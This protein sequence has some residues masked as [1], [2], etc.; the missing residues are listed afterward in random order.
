[1]NAKRV[2]LIGA[3]G[4]VGGHVLQSALDDERVASLTVIGRRPTGVS[5]PKLIEIVHPNLL[6]YAPVAAALADQNLA[7][8]CLGAIP[9]PFPT[10]S[11]GGSRSTTSRPFPRRST[12]PA[13]T[14]SSAS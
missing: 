5:H 1:M 13:R 8:F 12:P 14:R 9:G 10:T 4:M 11:C 7:L 3:T 6:D 2:L